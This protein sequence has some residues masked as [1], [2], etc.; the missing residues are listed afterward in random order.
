MKKIILT[1]ITIIT[2]SSCS[3]DNSTPPFVP[4]T[5]TPVLIGKGNFISG[6]VQNNQKI[7]NQTDWNTLLSSMSS[8]S[9]TFSDLTIDFSNFDVI[10]I[11]DSERPCSSYSITIDTIIENEDN[12]TITYSTSGANM[13]CYTVISQPYHLVKIPKI[14][15]P[16][17]FL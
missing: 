15:K 4:V 13:D 10:A 12:I 9:N 16:L 6:L 8:V 5:I 17:I 14:N 2:L 11:I 1:I 3:N 7:T